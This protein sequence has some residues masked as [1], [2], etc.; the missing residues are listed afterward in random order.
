MLM[1]RARA[2]GARAMWPLS[3]AEKNMPRGRRYSLRSQHLQ[4]LHS[5]NAIEHFVNPFV[6]CLYHRVHGNN[7]TL[8]TPQAP[9][10]DHKLKATLLGVATTPRAQCTLFRQRPGLQVCQRGRTCD[11]SGTPS[12]RWCCNALCRAWQGAVHRAGP[13]LAEAGKSHLIA[14]LQVLHTAQLLSAQHAG[15]W[16]SCNDSGVQAGSALHSPRTCPAVLTSSHSC[17]KGTIIDSYHH[18]LLLLF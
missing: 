8:V 15:G 4:L 2:G 1:P 17:A 5:V 6:T 7:C 13:G 9:S 3:A 11:S 10:V 18:I 16:G 12:P 14:V